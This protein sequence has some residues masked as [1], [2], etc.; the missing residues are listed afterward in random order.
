M[1]EEVPK[2]FMGKE[3]VPD[4]LQRLID[5]LEE[6]TKDL[7]DDKNF[8]AALEATLK[9]LET[10]RQNQPDDSS[11][12][13][14]W[15]EQRYPYVISLCGHRPFYHVKCFTVKSCHQRLAVLSL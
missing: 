15:S 13:S 6:R 5:E 12:D 1:P 4:D 2:V 10:R 11:I 14:T 8:E 9:K 3:S 7:K